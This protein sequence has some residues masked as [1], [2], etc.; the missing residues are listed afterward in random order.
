MTARMLTKDER[1][2]LG[3]ALGVLRANVLDQPGRRGGKAGPA[4]YEALLRFDVA[5]DYGRRI[6]ARAAWAIILADAL[7]L[8][9]WPY[10]CRRPKYQRRAER[11]LRA[12]LAL[13]IRA[14]LRADRGEDRHRVGPCSACDGSGIGDHARDP[15]TGEWTA[16]RC[17][18]VCDGHGHLFR[19]A[20]LWT[21][22]PGHEAGGEGR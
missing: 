3:A 5:E 15:S 16:S 9:A 2:M 22:A 18:E 19:I 21:T 8:A 17:C 10:P 14:V 20:P 1:R 11:I 4:L 13:A 12:R 7:R 6:E